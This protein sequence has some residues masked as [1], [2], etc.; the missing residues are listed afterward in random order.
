MPLKLFLNNKILSVIILTTVVQ[1]NGESLPLYSAR[2]GRIC[3]TCHLAPFENKSTKAWVD[4]DL[5][6]RKCSLSCQTCHVNPTGGGIRTAA[7]RYYY[8][9]TLPMF[10]S[11][12][13]PYWDR[14]RNIS[15]LIAWLKKDDATAVT[16]QK[17]PQ[18]A[19]QEPAKSDENYPQK[20]SA[21]TFADPFVYSV[22]Y[23]ADSD[24]LYSPRQG[25]YGEINADP[26]FNYGL[27]TR[28]AY[29]DDIDDQ[30]NGAVFPMQFDTSVAIHPVEH[31]TALSTVGVL[32]SSPN[33]SKKSFSESIALRDAFIMGHEAPYQSYVKAG[34]FKPNFGM[35][36]EDHTAAV[37]NEFELNTSRRTNSVAGLEI[38]A[39]PN[40]PYI[41]ASVFYDLNSSDKLR[42]KGGTF[43]FGWRDLGFSAGLS[44][45]T[46][47]RPPEREGNL[48]GTAIDFT[49][50]PFR[51]WKFIPVTILSETALGTKV[52]P[53]GYSRKFLASFV[54]LNILVLNG[55]N[56]H[57]NHYYFDP[58]TEIKGN[59]TGRLGLGFD[60]IPITYLRI[61]FEY[62]ITRDFDSGA[63]QLK[64]VLFLIHGYL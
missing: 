45:L 12:K 10:L 62:R 5:S 43:S 14:N 37:R 3:D 28:I 29:L 51:Y 1:F 31:L 18:P 22:S 54:E 6:E 53:F 40:Y 25:R 35:N 44:F 27:D 4:P 49:L 32:G 42:D 17:I 55:L 39:A 26:F 8:N 24:S 23:N 7:G 13:R 63:V 52:D 16:E 19:I 9:N 11:K 64:R 59:A 46:K 48:N 38:G 41:N 57:I 34:I 33:S 60:F 36:I 21:Y 2:S 30:K 15:G 61:T 50:N 47:K 56:L 20:H 58:N